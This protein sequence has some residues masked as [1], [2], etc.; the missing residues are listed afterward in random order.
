MAKAK[1]TKTDRIRE[2]Y[3]QGKSI[4]EIAKELGIRYQHAYNTLVRLGLHQPRSKKEKSAP[5]PEQPKVDPKVYAEFIRNIEIRAVLLEELEAQIGELPQGRLGFHLEI[6]PVDEEPVP[7]NGGFS[8]GL[9]FEVRFLVREK[10]GDKE[11]EFGHVRA[12][13]RG[14][15]Q[16]KALPE[17]EIFALFAKRNLPVNL[18]PYFRVQV[19]QITAQMGLPRLVLPAFKTVG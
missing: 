14:V 4:S 3:Q 12:V 18:W 16:S 19:D 10:E 7:L 6:K 1:P 8:A 9:Y 5:P 11:H 2:L 17:K 15:Y 13:W